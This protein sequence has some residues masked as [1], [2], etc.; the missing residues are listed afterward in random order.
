MGRRANNVAAVM[1]GKGWRKM[2]GKIE[3]FL[4]DMVMLTTHWAYLRPPLLAV[5]R[6]TR[7]RRH[8]VRAM[9]RGKESSNEEMILQH[10]K[11]LSSSC[12]RSSRSNKRG[13]EDVEQRLCYSKRAIPH[14]CTHANT[15]KHAHTHT[16]AHKRQYCCASCASSS[17]IV[18]TVGKT[19]AEA[20]LTCVL[21][22]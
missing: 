11:H 6:A 7:L 12:G 15:R 9:Q 18:F 2:K 4:E 14:T 3:G 1:E 13:R 5:R 17:S 22:R 21:P 16:H 10:W 8:P 20:T 19:E